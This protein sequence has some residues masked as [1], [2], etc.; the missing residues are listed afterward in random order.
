[1]F[2]FFL[3]KIGKVIYKNKFCGICNFFNFNFLGKRCD[4][5]FKNISIFKVCE[6]FLD[7][8]LCF[9]YKNVFCKLCSCDEMNFDCYIEIL[10]NVG[11][12]GLLEIIGIFSLVLFVLE[13]FM[14]RIFFILDV[15]KN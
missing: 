6:E 8:K 7:I 11:D 15:Y 4:I 5:N 9:L 1:M 10:L 3:I 13:I 12:I 14:F 2:W